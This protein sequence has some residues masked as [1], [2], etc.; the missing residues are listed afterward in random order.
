MAALVDGSPISLPGA[1]KSSMF[2]VIGVGVA[3]STAFRYAFNNQGGIMKKDK[4]PFS[5][6]VA[7]IVDLLQ[8]CLGIILILLIIS[9][10]IPQMS[11]GIPLL[12]VLILLAILTL[13][14]AIFVWLFINIG[15]LNPSARRVQILFSI[16]GLLE[17]PIGTILHGIILVGMF[18]EDT[19]EAF[20]IIPK[21]DPE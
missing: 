14:T 1:I 11:M 18:R 7:R 8:V 21:S 2:V 20:G 12:P 13:I 16:L 19:K 9:V 10:A 6:T 15:K 3:Y 17:F 4:W 5:V